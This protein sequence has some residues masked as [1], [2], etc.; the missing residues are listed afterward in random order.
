MKYKLA[1]VV[2]YIALQCSAAL[3]G[4]H[5]EEN[6]QKLVSQYL[7]ALARGDTE[8]LLDVIGG[9]LLKSRRALLE[10]PSYPGYLIEA[11]TDTS[12]SVAGTRQLTANSVEVDVV[13]EKAVDEQFRLTFLVKADKDKPE[14]LRIVSERD[15]KK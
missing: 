5:L 11:Y 2:I 9:D 7:D 14:T 13:I 4:T 1:A 12:V 10:N 8:L 3:A 6:A 15:A